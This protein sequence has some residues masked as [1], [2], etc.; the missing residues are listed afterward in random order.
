MLDRVSATAP[1]VVLIVEDELLLRELAVEF[2]EEAGFVALEARDAD[3]AVALLEAHSDIA[4]L[5]TDI[6]MPGSMN[7]LKLAHTVR[8]RWPPIKILVVS[9]QLRLGPSD[10]PSNG[11]FLGKP[12]YGGAVIA[13]LHSLIDPTGTSISGLTDNAR[14]RL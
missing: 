6:N 9:G 1:P 8:D 10:L 7:G 2:V 4:I 11:I 5:F 3:E 13:R 14:T 12:Y